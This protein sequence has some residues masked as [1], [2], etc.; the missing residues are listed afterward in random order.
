MGFA[1]GEWRNAMDE[2]EA[3]AYDA[4]YDAV[5]YAIGVIEIAGTT[6]NTYPAAEN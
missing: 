4:V 5:T 1:M 3:M 6:T 2:C